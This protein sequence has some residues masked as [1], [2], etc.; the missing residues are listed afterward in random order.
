MWNVTGID[1]GSRRTK[2]R[3]E[4]FGTMEMLKIG[5]TTRPPTGRMKGRAPQPPPQPTH[6]KVLTA[7][8]K[9]K[10][11]P[12][13]PDPKDMK[14][15]V[16]PGTLDL[17]VVL[18][19][20]T[21]KSVK[22]NESK[23]LMD[24]LIDLCSQN[25]LNPTHHTLELQSRETHKPLGF[26]PNTTVGIL[27]VDKVLIKQKVIEDKPRRF[28]LVMPEKTVRLIVN[29]QRT[30]KALLR[31]SPLVPLRE[32]LPVICEKCDFSVGH[33]V[34]LKDDIRREKV[35]L[36][37]S[38][39]DLETRELYALDA[40][41]DLSQN[42][43]AITGMNEKRDKGL[44][45]FLKIGKKKTKGY[46]TAPSTPMVNAR[47]TA[48]NSSLSTSNVS[49]ISQMMDVKKRRAPPPP[50][51][52]PECTNARRV[53]D[54]AQ[55]I[56]V[57][58]LNTMQKK[59]RAPAPPPIHSKLEGTEF[60]RSNTIV[61][62]ELERD[63]GIGDDIMGMEC[64]DG[65]EIASDKSSDSF[66]QICSNYTPD[67]EGELL[68]SDDAFTVISQS[69]IFSTPT[70]SLK[71]RNKTDADAIPGASNE[72]FV[73]K[74]HPTWSS[75]Q[76]STED[77]ESF[78]GFNT[79]FESATCAE[80]NWKEDKI[81][82]PA[83]VNLSLA[84]LDADLTA[85]QE[86]LALNKSTMSSDRTFDE[87]ET[88]PVTIIDEVSWTCQEEAEEKILL[89]KAPSPSKLKGLTSTDRGEATNS[90]VTTGIFITNVCELTP[91]GISSDTSY[92]SSVTNC[93]D[94]SRET[95]ETSIET[96][97]EGNKDVHDEM[98]QD[99]KKFKMTLPS[100]EL[101]SDK[102]V[103]GNGRKKVH[104]AEPA[105]IGTTILEDI[106]CHGRQVK[107]CSTATCSPEYISTSDR[108]LI[109]ANKITNECLP[110]IGM[111]TFTVIPPKPNVKP[112]QRE[113][114]SLKSSAIKIDDQG[115]LIHAKIN[116]RKNEQT[117]TNNLA[118]DQESLV[119]RAKAFWNVR[120]ADKDNLQCA[121][122]AKVLMI[123]KSEV[124]ACELQPQEPEKQLTS[125]FPTS[126]A[127][128]A[129]VTATSTKTIQTC[130]PS[131]KE[132]PL[133]SVM[134]LNVKITNMP[135]NS[136]AK[137][138]NNFIRPCR[139]NSSQY[140]ASAI[141]RYTGLQSIK[142]EA[143]IESNAQSSAQY[144]GK[145]NDINKF[146]T[147][148]EKPSPLSSKRNDVGNQQNTE[149]AL[150]SS[151]NTHNDTQ[152]LNR[153]NVLPQENVDTEAIPR[154]N[155]LIKDTSEKMNA[156]SKIT[157]QSQRS[158]L[159]IKESI[160]IDDQYTCS[161]PQSTFQSP[162]VK[163]VISGAP[164]DQTINM[165]KKHAFTPTSTSS[166][167]SVKAFST[168]ANQ[169]N[170]FSDNPASKLPT[171]SVTTTSITESALDEES[172]C[173]LSC[174]LN[175]FNII[176]NTNMFGPVKRFKPI[177]Q[178]PIQKDECIHSSLMKAI[179]SGQN[180][181]RLRKTSD[182]I[183]H[184]N[185]KKSSII[186]IENEHSAL[187]ASIRAHSGISKLKKTTSLASKEI[188]DPKNVASASTREYFQT[189]QPEQ[190]PPC[191]PP[192]K[193][194]KFST[195]PLV[196]QEAR[197]ALLKAIQ[198]GT[199]AALLRKVSVPSN[200]IEINGRTSTV[201]ISTCWTPYISS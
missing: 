79:R 138:K 45:G 156:F 168:E 147:V 76:I 91:S 47:S 13:D 49:K 197:T 20:G 3:Q 83:Q 164:N 112:Q 48:L 82:I 119:R 80:S 86:G 109:T 50:S 174:N 183:M 132:K 163:D 190:A 67:S 128:V 73:T 102:Q 72:I 172:E 130:S 195:K 137:I 31:V 177:I 61:E 142:T 10:V 146:R 93:T 143:R 170:Y 121:N 39:N 65:E 29:F 33:V 106:N 179:Q 149:F 16:L 63:G 115:N 17:L 176:P 189:K 30:Q 136:Q 14:E 193:T 133:L 66:Q 182:K 70:E 107:N 90:K 2:K 113:Y 22:V 62:L 12:S 105:E 1:G 155:W 35:D 94:I 166:S 53:D 198:S 126:D 59:R 99:E 187:L 131:T 92:P 24:L 125:T 58:S 6:H 139:R 38:L 27:N 122:V 188:Q 43:L 108:W 181:E 129:Q 42:D 150:H 167:D 161:I 148:E 154:Q 116:E 28:Q 7:T 77:K 51:A 37:K 186:A 117:D 169:S 11:L 52:T 34:L 87:Q 4:E 96:L 64:A 171:T 5:V 74:E 104:S 40:S 184:H 185:Q 162:V 153:I 144:E 158:Q 160:S 152:V 85:L 84:R 9:C 173:S 46:S 118:S 89:E 21:E 120:S 123:N 23:A 98:K 54:S 56:G 36:S 44:L 57:E 60:D 201:H 32:L 100:T 97:H 18:P 157:S 19:N 191:C 26:K 110:K 178:K 192:P 135:V 71:L 81:Y 180:K 88:V 75:D 111:R 8:Q 196:N 114:L 127:V 134:P 140:I 159:I 68:K 25:H 95:I 141:C 78:F 175:S 199:G 200:T 151:Y 165:T 69:D 194:E 15:N 124:I 101:V 145:S 55:E 41:R 103:R